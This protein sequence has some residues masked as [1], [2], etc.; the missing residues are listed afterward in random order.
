MLT[1]NTDIIIHRKLRTYVYHYC[2][3]GLEPYF[4][5]EVNRAIKYTRDFVLQTVFDEQSKQKDYGL[6]E[7]EAL[8]TL[9]M[10]ATKWAQDNA[11]TV[12]LNDAIEAQ[13]IREQFLLEQ[14]EAELTVRAEK[15]HVLGRRGVKKT[16]SLTQQEANNLA[17][18]HQQRHT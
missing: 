18:A 10:E 15:G 11:L 14:I 3:R 13:E 6:D 9:C 16:P 17:W 1:V 2:L 4:S 12:G 8:R 7:P 5:L